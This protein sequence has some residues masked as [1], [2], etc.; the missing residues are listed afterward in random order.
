MATIF[1]D[2]YDDVTVPL[3]DLIKT[4]KEDGDTALEKSARTA[5]VEF[6]A[7]WQRAAFNHQETFEYEPS[8]RASAAWLATWEA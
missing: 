7:H 4:A 1:R 3:N 2:Q 6:T 5:I 8:S